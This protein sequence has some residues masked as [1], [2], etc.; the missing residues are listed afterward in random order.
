MNI[1]RKYTVSELS[2]TLGLST[3]WINKIDRKI[4]ITAGARKDYKKPCFRQ[5]DLFI[6]RNIKLLR[7]L[8]YS[9]PDIKKIYDVEKKMLSCRAIVSKYQSIVPKHGYHYILHPYNF[10]YDEHAHPGQDMKEYDS[11]IIDYKGWAEFLYTHSLEIEKRA[12]QLQDEI[13]SLAEAISN[14]AQA[15]KNIG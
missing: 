11:E 8:G 4:G 10:T 3:S 7:I 14:N 6:F 9:I 13:T 15:G 12:K 5:D 1:Q 2:I